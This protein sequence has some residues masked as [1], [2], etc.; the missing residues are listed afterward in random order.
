LVVDNLSG[1]VKKLQEMVDNYNS[2][3]GSYAYLLDG[4]GGVIAHP[5]RQQVN[6]V[7][8][9]KTMKKSVLVRDA[10]GENIK[11]EKNNERTVEIDFP[12]PPSM[13]AIIAK[14]MTGETGVGEYTDLN[15]DKNIC[16]YRTISLPGKSDPWSL[17][18]VQKKS[19]ALA[20][21]YDVTKKNIQV[22][23]FVLALSALL[24]FRFSRRITNPLIDIVN[25]TNQIKDGDLTVRLD[26]KSSNEIGVLAM[27][28][29]KMVSEIQQHREG[30]EELVAGRTRDLDGA[31]QELTAL[32]EEMIA[33]NEILEDTNKRL[34]D[35]NKARRQVEDNLL[36]RERQY[37]ALLAF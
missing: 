4:D 31:N 29:N 22:S 21:M 8:N 27:N 32:N 14:V 1:V 18:V 11:D 30:L 24:T 17:I 2:G 34:E 3:E 26:I 7:Y 15:G 36:L 23:L 37:R 20:F 5:D 33:M 6:E 10:N 35:E 9:Y 19:V 16:A 13:Q 28:F 25:A 12:V